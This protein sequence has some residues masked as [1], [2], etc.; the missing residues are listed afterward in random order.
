MIMMIVN[1]IVVVKMIMIVMVK[2]IMVLVM[3]IMTK[4]DF[5]KT[6]CCENL[7]KKQ[8]NGVYSSFFSFESGHYDVAGWDQVGKTIDMPEIFCK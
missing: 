8:P 6:R 3:M 5:M 2:K 1:V 4:D 7:H